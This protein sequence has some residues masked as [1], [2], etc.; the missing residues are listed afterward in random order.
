MRAE[1]GD[2][3]ALF[4][5]QPGFLRLLAVRT[6]SQFGGGAF[7]VGLA[8]LF[9]FNPQRATT[10]SGVAWA[11]TA[12]LLPY[13]LV[14][15]FAGVLLDRWFRR[16]VLLVAGL[17]R[18]GLVLAAAALVGTGA[19]VWTLM[20]VALVCLGLDRFVLAGVQAALPHVVQRRLLV[21]A[22]SLTP[23][24]GTISMLVGIGCGF[25]LVQAVGGAGAAALLL[26]AAGYAGATLATLTLGRR[27]LGP[28]ERPAAVPL[29][30]AAVQ[31]VGGMA[32]GARHV[33]GRAPARWAFALIVVTRLGFGTFT[34]AT[35][36]LARN[37]FTD[38]VQAGLDLVAVIV[39][40]A[41][42]GTGLAAV[43]T[44]AGL[45]LL[46]PRV[47][48]TLCLLTVTGIYLTWAV[49][50][51]QVLFVVLAL[52]LGLA[53]QGTKIVVDTT[54]QVG[55]LEPFWGRVFSLADVAFNLALVLAALLAVVFVPASGHPPGLLLALAALHLTLTGWTLTRRAAP[56]QPV[57]G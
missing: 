10:P 30:G 51:S 7:T 48:V 11:L 32:A 6:L 56:L 23:T 27:A 1:R 15:P 45:A 50:L 44:P 35:I 24:L 54:L 41:G 18:V 57:P 19:P 52:P 4:A 38:D 34:V 9:F 39:G 26:G 14:S 55:T 53:V 29:V 21:L 20:V 8:G 46:R 25:A 40:S 42:L 28:D 22:N 47:W 16:Q 5:R 43:V 17:A 12:G 31:I 3:V 36:L 49:A 37:T 2:V 33:A 13:T